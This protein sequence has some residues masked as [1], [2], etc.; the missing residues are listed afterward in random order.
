MSHLDLDVF[1]ETIEN[2][3]TDFSNV[4][5]QAQV[6][7]NDDIKIPDYK[8]PKEKIISAQHNIIINSVKPIK[9]SVGCGKGPGCKLLVKGNIRVGIEYSAAVPE[10]NVHFLHCDLPFRGLVISE[11]CERPIP[12]QDCDLSK[13]DL[14][15]CTEHF[16]LDQIDSRTIHQ[17]AVLLLWLSR[18]PQC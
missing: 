14:Y 16:Q 10:Q 8:P 1:H 3:P 7:I 9:V 5:Y 2:C 18:K 17:V 12:H 4:A 6:I 15:V 11:R 13:F